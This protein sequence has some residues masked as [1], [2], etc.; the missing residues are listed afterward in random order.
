MAYKIEYGMNSPYGYAKKSFSKAREKAPG[1]YMLFVAII[2][3]FVICILTD[4]FIPGDAAITKSAINELIADVKA[5]E[6]VVDAFAEFCQTVLQI[7]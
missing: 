2:V 1:K 6:Q 3:L 5:G 4:S 7:S